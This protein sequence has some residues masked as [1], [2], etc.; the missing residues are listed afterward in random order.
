VS[1]LSAYQL[2]VKNRGKLYIELPANTPLGP[3]V[4]GLPGARNYTSNSGYEVAPP[5]VIA[6]VK[7]KAAVQKVVD[8]IALYAADNPL[9]VTTWGSDWDYAVAQ[10]KKTGDVIRDG[11]QQLNDDLPGLPNFNVVLV[12]FA[13]VAVVVALVVFAPEVKRLVRA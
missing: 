12:V 4:A 1:K 11:V 9:S 6:E 10:T 8:A 2:D 7:S 3:S 5:L 13:I